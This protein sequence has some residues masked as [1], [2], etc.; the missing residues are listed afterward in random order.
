MLL[1]AVL[2]PQPPR[3]VPPTLSVC[4]ASLDDT[5]PLDRER[6]GPLPGRA[7]VSLLT[8]P[9]GAALKVQKA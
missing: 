3:M 7:G 5:V 1:G 6:T 9:G 8:G 2:N 4:A